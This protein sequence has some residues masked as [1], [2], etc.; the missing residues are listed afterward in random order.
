MDFGYLRHKLATETY[1]DYDIVAARAQ[2]KDEMALNY[3]K[4]N[5]I[6]NNLGEEIKKLELEDYRFFQKLGL[7]SIKGIRLLKCKVD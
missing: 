4:A 1:E 5:R 7:N 3:I 6:L 2:G